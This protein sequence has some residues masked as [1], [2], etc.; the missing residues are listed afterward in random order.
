MPK[1]LITDLDRDTSPYNPNRPS[2]FNMKIEKNPNK[3][4]QGIYE[5]AQSVVTK[6]F[7]QTTQYP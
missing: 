4:T 6:V 1:T 5:K 7:R 2:Y 3:E